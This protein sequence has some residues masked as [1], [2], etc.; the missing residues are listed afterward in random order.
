VEDASSTA[1]FDLKIFGDKGEA[2]VL[3]QGDFFRGQ[4]DRT[5][6]LLPD[7]GEID[8]IDIEYWN[9]EDY[10]PLRLEKILIEVNGQALIFDI[11]QWLDY[12]YYLYVQNVYGILCQ[13]PLPFLPS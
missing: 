2:Y 3:L 5:E 12:S 6:Y 8:Y 13:T 11:A 1:N 7:V 4:V 10:D 9:Y